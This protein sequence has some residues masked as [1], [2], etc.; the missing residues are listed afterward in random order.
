LVSTSNVSAALRQ[1]DVQSLTAQ[2]QQSTAA[3]RAPGRRVTVLGSRMRVVSPCSCH[4]FSHVIPTEMIPRGVQIVGPATQSQILDRRQPAIRPRLYVIDLQEP[5]RRTAPTL[6]RHERAAALV[7]LIDHARGVGGHVPRALHGACLTSTD[8][9]RARAVRRTIV[10]ASSARLR[11]DAK[12]RF[13]QLRA[14]G[15][16]G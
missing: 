16:Q 2:S 7:A 6:F 11:S 8:V 14:I 9:F 12:A 15:L 4:R 10:T 3:L 5:S 13:P 1:S